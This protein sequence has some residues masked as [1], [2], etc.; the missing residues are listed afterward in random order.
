MAKC[1]LAVHS[2]I[3]EL[4]VITEVNETRTWNLRKKSRTRQSRALKKPKTLGKRQWEKERKEWRKARTQL[5]KDTKK[6]KRPP[7]KQRTESTERVAA[8]LYRIRGYKP[9]PSLSP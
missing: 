4:P 6:R 1:Q 7:G 8:Q 5:A 2:E 9:L 3:S